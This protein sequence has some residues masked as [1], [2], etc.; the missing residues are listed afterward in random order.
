MAENQCC[1]TGKD[2]QVGG[3]RERTRG[4]LE[5]WEEGET[6]T[7]AKAEEETFQKLKKKKR[8]DRL[9]VGQRIEEMWRL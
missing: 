4:G 1:V 3:W 5:A 6:G 9:K 2:L 8:Q 7:G